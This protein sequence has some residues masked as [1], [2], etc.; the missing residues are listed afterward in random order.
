MRFPWATALMGFSLLAVYAYSSG[1]LL[2]PD[3][4]IVSQ[5][6]FG[7]ANPLALVFSLFFHIGAYH[8]LGNLVPFLVFAALLE[9]SL[10]GRHVLAVF[11]ASGVVAAL[12][13]LALNPH[14]YLAGAS[15]GIS[16]LLTASA[17]LRPKFGMVL[18]FLVPVFMG[19]VAFPTL[20]LVEKTA[21]SAL[22]EKAALLESQ[23]DRFEASGQLEQAT[24]VRAQAG[25]ANATLL[26]QEAAKAQEAR[27]APDF[28]VHA[29][30]A[31][32]GVLYVVGFF[33][34][35]VREGFDELA[36]FFDSARARFGRG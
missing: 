9:Y 8:L 11:I 2:Y 22:G 10:S 32:V 25:A 5:N 28:L 30:G 20:D 1:G 16:G 18:L 36:D 33:G 34:S 27:S 6:A 23:A 35:R 14:A 26:Q 31:L 21:F 19:V 12:V 3:F 13:F 15:G 4:S 24:A 29:A 7:S 17:L